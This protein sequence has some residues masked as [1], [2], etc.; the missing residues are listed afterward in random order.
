MRTLLYDRKLRDKNGHIV[1]KFLDKNLEG[2]Y[3]P[4][5]NLLK[6]L[7]DKTITCVNLKQDGLKSAKVISYKDK[8][9]LTRPLILH[10]NCEKSLY[11]EHIKT[12]TVEAFMTKKSI[13]DDRDYTSYKMGPIRFNK[14]VHI[15]IYDD[16]IRILSTLPIV[17][18]EG[19]YLFADT[20]FEKI[21]IASVEFRCTKLDNIFESAKAK[22]ISFIPNI[23]VND[24]E[25]RFKTVRSMEMAFKSTQ[26]EKIK[27]KELKFD[28][29]TEAMEM[30]ADSKIGDIGIGKWK[31]PNL[32]NTTQM[33]AWSSLMQ[34]SDFTGFDF[35][36]VEIADEMFLGFNATY[37]L[38]M[39]DLDI[40]SLISSDGMF[41]SAKFDEFDITFVNVGYIDPENMFDNALVLTGEIDISS[42]GYSPCTD[43]YRAVNESCCAKVEF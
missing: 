36:R 19:D 21:N 28:S 34:K 18:K 41:A 17:V 10:L 33:F 7:N 25:N 11:V 30:F 3:V 27:F 38:R 42:L 37:G 15:Y 32:R 1:Y 2:F 13:I 4:I 24:C 8:F 26:I 31:M 5:Q 40:K 29:L 39:H 22:E 35:G 43:S 6:L 12:N 9:I 14:N 16:C 20:K 23:G